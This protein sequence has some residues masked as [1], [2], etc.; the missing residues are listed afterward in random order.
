[1][2]GKLIDLYFRDGCF[3]A[4]VEQSGH[5]RGIRFMF[6]SRRGVINE[7]RRVYKISCSHDFY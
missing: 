1:M 2:N 3:I 6:Y 7:L 5:I 4:R